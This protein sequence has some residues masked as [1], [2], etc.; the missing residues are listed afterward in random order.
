VFVIAAAYFSFLKNSDPES[1][2]SW[3]AFCLRSA[4]GIVVCTALLLPVSEIFARLPEYASSL[5]A[6]VLSMLSIPAGANVGGRLGVLCGAVAVVRP[7]GICLQRLS[8]SVLSDQDDP[9]L[10]GVLY[11]VDANKQSAEHVSFNAAMLQTLIAAAQERGCRFALFC[12]RRHRDAIVSLL[13]GRTEIMWHEIPVVNGFDRTFVKKFVVELVTVCQLIFKAKR[14]RADV[15]LLS[16][17]P[18]VLACV[19]LLRRLFRDVRVHVI[20]HGELESLLIE[21]KRPIYRKAFG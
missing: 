16:A 12:E 15:L 4:A 17:F 20:L 2:T 5:F 11:I 7:A 21:E 1:D 8:G 18:N 10:S 9:G 19:L 6:V 3:S 14:A 13:P